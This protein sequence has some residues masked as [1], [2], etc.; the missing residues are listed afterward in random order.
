MK[1]SRHACVGNAVRRQT[2]NATVPVA[3]AGEKGLHDLNQS[4]PPIAYAGNKAADWHAG[5]AIEEK[6]AKQGLPNVFTSDS[7]EAFLKNGIVPNGVAPLNLPLP[8]LLPLLLLTR[9]LFLGLRLH[10]L[11]LG[12]GFALEVHAVVLLR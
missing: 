9:S 4:L 3:G 1:N 5:Q 10:G 11:L 2:G 6:V 8:P 12:P 7:S